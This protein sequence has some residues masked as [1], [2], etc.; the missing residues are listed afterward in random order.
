MSVKVMGRVWDSDLRSTEKFVLLAYADHASHDGTNIFPAIESMVEKTGFSERTVQSATR[1]LEGKGWLIPDGKG[2]KGTSKWKI[3][4]KAKKELHPAGA[5]PPQLNRK[6]GAANSEKMESP[7]PEPLLT[8][9]EPSLKLRDSLLSDSADSISPSEDPWTKA[10]VVIG[11]TYYPKKMH[12]GSSDWHKYWSATRYGSVEDGKFVVLCDTEE[13]RAWL[14]DR[15]T[16]IAER[17]L[18][19]MLDD[20]DVEVEFVV[21]EL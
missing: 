15:G 19:E 4:M 1:E 20:E 3:P 11:S 18:M 5:A 14:E 16:S 21:S 10:L 6:R 7:A 8:V 12:F 13:Q 17:Q 9:K 2:P